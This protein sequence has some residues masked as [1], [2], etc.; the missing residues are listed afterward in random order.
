M[1]V[2]DILPDV[3]SACEQPENVLTPAFFDEHLAVVARYATA[4]APAV[5]AEP[6]AVELAAWLHDFSAVL[7]FSTLPT[8]PAVSADLAGAMLARFGYPEERVALVTD[9]I[10]KHS[11]PLAPGAG[12]PEAVCLSNADAMA[13]IACPAF[14][15][16]FAFRVRKLDYAE[17]K[18]WYRDRVRSNWEALIPEARALVAVEHARTAALID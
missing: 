16:Y 13:Q 6:E 17:G 2:D 4:L 1:I 3:R 5:G 11:S 7:D 12:S 10:A 15:L 18:R 14:W 9:A 8:H